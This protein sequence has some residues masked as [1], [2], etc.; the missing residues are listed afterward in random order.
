MHAE[1]CS[2]TAVQQSS[3]RLLG[4]LA[5]AS[6]ACGT[7]TFIWGGMSIDVQRGAFVR[8]HRDVDGFTFDLLDVKAEMMA[9]LA[10]KGYSCSY[11][12]RFDMLKV[13]SGKLHAGLNRLETRQGC[14]MWRHVGNHGTIFFPLEWL[15]VVPRDFH[16]LRLYTSGARFEYAIKTHAYLLNPTWQLRQTDHEAIEWLSGELDRLAVDRQ[17]ILSQIW[18]HTPFW[19]QRGYPQYAG[20]VRVAASASRPS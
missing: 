2:L 7:R 5:D 11:D 17:E 14:A 18:S 8:D 1:A 9:W 10:A 12:D 19:A 16:G 15:D 3:L 13:A 20:L 4:D 6:A